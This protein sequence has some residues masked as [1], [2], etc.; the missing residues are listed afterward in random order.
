LDF[1]KR[2][3]GSNSKCTLLLA[4]RST[5]KAQFRDTIYQQSNTVCFDQTENCFP[6]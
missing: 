3:A 5:R 4:N 1:Q 6:P 2:R